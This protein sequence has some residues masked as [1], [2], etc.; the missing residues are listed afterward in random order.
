MNTVPIWPAFIHPTLTYLADGKVAK[1]REIRNAV[2]KL[3]ELDSDA[4]S[5]MLES[6]EARAHNRSGWAI[7]Y[8]HQAGWLE[9]VSRGSYRITSK[10][11]QALNDYPSGINSY[12]QANR[13][14]AP[15][16]RR[17]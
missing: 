9:R 4:L 2:Y 14:F 1:N 12:G 6:G 16:V 5:E 15:F 11:Q 8:M 13:I 17:K 7:T 10:G 3:L